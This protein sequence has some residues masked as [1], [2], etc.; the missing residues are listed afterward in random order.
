MFDRE[1]IRLLVLSQP[2]P[3][4]LIRD[5]GRTRLMRHVRPYGARRALTPALYETLKLLAQGLTNRQIGEQLQ[6]DEETARARVKRL[7]AYFDV[8]NRTELA[9]R[10][11]RE[12]II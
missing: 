2:I 7:L 8:A 10:C 9:A 6:I 12:R 11:Y 3:D 1:A 5:I 4:A